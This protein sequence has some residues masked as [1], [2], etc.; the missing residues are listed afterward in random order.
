MRAVSMVKHL[1]DEQ[2]PKT[3]PF[4][5]VPTDPAA[6]RFKPAFLQW[7]VEEEVNGNVS[8]SSDMATNR[9]AEMSVGIAQDESCSLLES[10]MTFAI[11]TMQEVEMRISPK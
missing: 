4:C 9:R 1:C 7:L 5:P 8:D 10:G 2:H 3:G 6:Y 11:L